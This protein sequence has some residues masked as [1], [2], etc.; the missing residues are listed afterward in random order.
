MI[1]WIVL[2]MGGLGFMLGLNFSP[3]RAWANLLLVAYFLTGIGF[4]GMMLVAIHYVSNA[5]WDTAVRRIPEAMFTVLTAGLVLML[6]IYLGLN[7][8]CEWSIPDVLDHDKLLKGKEAWLNAPGFMIRIVIYFTFWIIVGNKIRNHSRIQDTDG[9]LQH[10]ITARRWSALWL[11]IGGIMFIFSSFDWI[12]SL[13]PHWY[14]TI[15]GLYNF[16]ERP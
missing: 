9:R 1:L 14:S 11:Y 13:E 3:A 16:S 4:C 5:G 2:I 15:F 12:M 7:W 10:N 8:L 6:L